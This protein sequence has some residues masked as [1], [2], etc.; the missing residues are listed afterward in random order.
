MNQLTSF[1]HVVVKVLLG[2]QLACQFRWQDFVDVS[3]IRHGANLFVSHGD[4]GR[5]FRESVGT[6]LMIEWFSI[7]MCNH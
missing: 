6:I 2:P 1:V 7:L 5:R 3:L 4:F